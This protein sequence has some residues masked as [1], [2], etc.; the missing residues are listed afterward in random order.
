M[1]GYIGRYLP[2]DIEV[3]LAYDIDKRK[4]A[5]SLSR[6]IFAEPNCTKTIW[7]E[8]L[9]DNDIVECIVKMGKILDGFSLHLMDYDEKNR[10]VLSK[11]KEP[12]K[13]DIVKELKDTG[14]EI[15]LNY[16]PVGSVKATEFYVEC[17]LEAGVALINNI[18]EFIA[19]SEEWS[20]RFKQ[21]GI[22]LLGDDVKSQLGATITHRVLVQLFRD[23]G[24]K[25]DRTYQLNTA[26][27][28][29]F[30][31]ML[32]RSRL[33]SKKISKTEA[34]QSILGDRKLNSEDIH[35]G[36]SDYVPFL[37]D[38][39]IAYIRMEGRLFGDVP[40]NL[41][42]R[43]SVEDSANSAGCVI[44]AIRIVRV[45]LDRKIGGTLIGPSAFYFKHPIEQYSDNIAM[46]MTEK[47]INSSDIYED[48]RRHLGLG[49]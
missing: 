19:S 5:T 35:I 47:F 4:V 2:S 17:C 30:L 6:A 42:L 23:R 40:M 41:E 46:E 13:E 27:N 37:K 33:K 32:D 36:P 14:T 15:L 49:V 1:H 45:A 18:P 26:G 24:V 31:N 39:K 44:D 8:Y 12:T 25:L 9:F 48:R 43:L 20:E 22:P 29:D 7:N 10:I 11:E 34:V 28:L 21:K 3:V 38:N 16:L